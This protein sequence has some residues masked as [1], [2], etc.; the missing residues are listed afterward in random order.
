M[1]VWNPPVVLTSGELLSIGRQMEDLLVLVPYPI[2][3]LEKQ[4]NNKLITNI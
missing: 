1:D 2:L 3:V 4:L